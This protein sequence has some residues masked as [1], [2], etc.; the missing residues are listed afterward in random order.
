[1]VVVVGGASRGGRGLRL[2][3]GL[4]VEGGASIY[5]WEGMAL[6]A[7]GTCPTS[8]Y[9][10]KYHNAEYRLMEESIN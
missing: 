3:E 1:M 9:T 4:E 7:K 8:R 10:V 6:G 2:W 5:G